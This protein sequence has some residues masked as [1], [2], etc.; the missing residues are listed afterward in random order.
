MMDPKRKMQIPE[1][2][3]QQWDD[4]DKAKIF[5]W[6]REYFAYRAVFGE[7]L[8]T[9]NEDFFSNAIKILEEEINGGEDNESESD[10]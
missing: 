3:K 1:I 4:R 9:Y 6:L 2:T 10:L 5:E 8:L 7:S